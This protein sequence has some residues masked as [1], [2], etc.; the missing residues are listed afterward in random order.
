MSESFFD[1]LLRSVDYGKPFIAEMHSETPKMEV[2]FNKSYSEYNLQE[3]SEKFDRP[4]VE[5]HLGYNMSLYAATFGKLEGDPSKPKWGV[6]V[7]WKVS[8]HTLDDMWEPVTA[9]V[10]NTDYRFGGPE[11]LAIIYFS[12]IPY[13]KNISFSWLPVFHECTHL[14]DEVTIYRKDINFPVTRINISYE[15]TE[16][17]VT[18]NDPDGTLENNHSLRAGVV[19]RLSDRGNGWYEI[20]D[21]ALVD[22]TLTFKDSNERFEYYFQYQFQRSKGPLASKRIVNVLSVEVR[23]R[24]RYGYPIFKKDGDQWE[25]KE[26]GETRMWTLNAYLGLKFYPKKGGESLGLFLHYYKGMNPY[27]QLRNYPSYGFLGFSITYEP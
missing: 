22:K 11:I 26:I 6:A 14:G 1:G 21:D 25:T 7:N 9:A 19:F 3:E 18:V 15:F 10:I 12:D 4:M 16:F 24:V 5:V 23:N 2:G 17:H 20:Q 13:L 27:G 8:M